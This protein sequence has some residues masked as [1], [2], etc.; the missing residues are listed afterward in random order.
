[1][2]PKTSLL[3]KHL[4]NVGSLEETV[5]I[6]NHFYANET[7]YVISCG[8]SLNS[9]DTGQLA[10]VLNGRLVMTVKQAFNLFPGQSDF[11]VYNNFN[12]QK[13]VYGKSNTT[14]RIFGCDP[15]CPKIFGPEP[16]LK[17]TIDPSFEKPEGV[18]D[19]LLMHSLDFDRYLLSR[20]LI[21]PCGYGILYELVFYLAVHM[22]VR[23]CIVI[24]W[25]LAAKEA[26]Y[27]R[28]Y[29]S[30]PMP[31]ILQ[32]GI[33]ILRFLIGRRRTE[34]FRAWTRYQLGYIY[35]EQGA[36]PNEMAPLIASTRHV[37]AWLRRQ[38]VEL[39]VVSPVSCVDSAIPRLELG[40][41]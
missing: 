7:L 5:R 36:L 26:D 35:N 32:K 13:Y 33:S 16:D 3:K 8:P 24:G 21:R 19:N 2:H 27:K 22:G 29:S 25:D 39:A 9:I 23:R 17:F 30:R 31:W 41:L 12:H 40:D 20:T 1:M 18:R 37:H 11:H 34:R 38:G 28:F 6:L 4:R 10:R 14:I 15:Y